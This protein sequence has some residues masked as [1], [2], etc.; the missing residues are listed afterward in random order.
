MHKQN[1]LRNTIFFSCLFAI[2]LSNGQ[3]LDIPC[4]Y[5]AF[6]TDSEIIIDGNA[7]ETDWDKVAWSTNFID[8]EGTKKPKYNT[9]FKMLWDDTYMYYYVEMEEPHVWANLR[10][11]DTVVYYNNDFE[12]FWDPDG[13]THNYYEFEINAL[14]TIWDLFLTKPYRENNATMDSWDIRGAKSAIV[15]NGTLNNSEDTDKGWQLELAIPW[16]AFRTSFGQNNV[17]VNKFWRIN[18]SRVN[19]DF[20]LHNG[21]YDRKKDTKGKYLPEYN[22]VW[23]PQGVINMHEPEK[24]G[25]VYFTEK[26]AGQ[27]TSFEIPQEEQIRWHLYKLYRQMKLKQNNCLQ[28]LSAITGST[29]LYNN[30]VLTPILERHHSGWN[31]FIKTPKKLYLIREDG[32]Y[33]ITQN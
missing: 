33:S 26:K 22:W 16:S 3:S 15:V 10:Q 1:I 17:P 25:Y 27:T 6:R 28:N 18:F 19:W 24:W 14:N 32:K 31:I 21:T 4:T 5:T 11:R 9:H 12:I 7:K 29:L 20:D 23:S 8:I 2:S 13:D 30:Q